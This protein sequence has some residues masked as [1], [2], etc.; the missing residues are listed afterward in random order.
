MTIGRRPRPVGQVAALAA[1][2]LLALLGQKLIDIWVQDAGGNLAFLR[3]WPG[4]VLVI[5]VCA[6]IAYLWL[7]RER[8]ATDLESLVA[9]M[10]IDVRY[11]PIPSDD[12]ER[13]LHRRFG[14]VSAWDA[15]RRAIENVAPSGRVIVVRY[16]RES[17]ALDERTSSARRRYLESLERLMRQAHVYQ[18]VQIPPE[19]GKHV[20]TLAS[21]MEPTLYNHLRSA[22]SIRDAMSDQR[23]RVHVDA[24]TALYPMS[25]VIIQNPQDGS[26]RGTVLWEMVK[27]DADGGGIVPCGLF[28]ID[29][30]TGVI[31][32]TFLNWSKELGARAG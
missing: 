15:A 19:M 32:E 24:V 9:R 3:G 30:A 21:T 12:Q 5:V 25:F 17:R 6:A 4:A 14:E 26:R 31:I 2:A 22:V 8:H 29:D 20:D 16:L 23:G 1:T 27:H 18:I 13:A 10:G 7:R 28:I 11:Y